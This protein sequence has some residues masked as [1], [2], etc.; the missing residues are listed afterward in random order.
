MKQ[1]K[2]V[3]TLLLLVFLASC[4]P[5]SSQ[6]EKYEGKFF[7]SYTD[8]VDND[9]T[10]EYTFFT[11]YDKDD[12]RF[13]VTFNYGLHFH[14]EIKITEYD[15]NTWYHYANEGTF[16]S[17]YEKAIFTLDEKSESE[18]FPDGEYILSHHFINNKDVFDLSVNGNILHLSDEPITPPTFINQNLIGEFKYEDKFELSLTVG[19]LKDK[20]PV[21]IVIKENDLSFNA[22]NLVVSNN[23]VSFDIAG[24]TNGE[25]IKAGKGKL[26]IESSKVNLTI[27]EN[28]Y[29]LTKKEKEVTDSYFSNK[30]NTSTFY[31]D[32]VSITL[33]NMMGDSYRYLLIDELEEGGK[34]NISAL[35]SIKDNGNIL[36]N[37]QSISGNIIFL[38]GN[39]YKLTHTII[40]NKDKID[41]YKNNEILFEDLNIR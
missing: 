7:K 25:Y 15:I 14:Y 13:S 41:L 18:L 17:D 37:Q 16:S 36:I 4:A 38:T 31:N 30:D 10:K 1:M 26:N 24:T 3:L 27:G 11:L 21:S 20:R 34:R 6:E 12:N 33:S 5:T 29:Q 8:T 32:K 28:I 19:S 2:K 9:D 23:A 39:S 35:F 22:S 40:N